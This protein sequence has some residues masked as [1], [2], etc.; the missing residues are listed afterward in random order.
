[1]ITAQIPRL[2][3]LVQAL[4]RKARNHALA[5][6]AERR[7]NADPGEQSWRRAEWLWPTFTSEQ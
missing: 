6:I 3:G 7:V 2:A 5:L 1:M 4:E